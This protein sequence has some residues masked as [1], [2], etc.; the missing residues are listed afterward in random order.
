MNARQLDVF[1]DLLAWEAM[2]VRA[3]ESTEFRGAKAL[4]I[5]GTSGSPHSYTLQTMCKAGWVEDVGYG[6]TT[7]YRSNYGT[8]PVKTGQRRVCMWKTT[9][10]GRRVYALLKEAACTP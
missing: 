4:D 10:E 9:P 2:M 8:G 7:K 1:S 3:T 6:H 5:G